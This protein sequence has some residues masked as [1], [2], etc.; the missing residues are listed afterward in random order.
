MYDLEIKIGVDN[1]NTA[2][3]LAQLAEQLKILGT[4]T[5]GVTRQLSANTS[6]SR[7]NAVAMTDEEKAAAQLQKAQE[8]LRAQLE[9]NANTYGKSRSEVMAYKAAQLGLANDVGIS[10]NIQKLHQAELD[11]ASN[12]INRAKGVVSELGKSNRLT[13]NETLNLSRQLSDV[14]VTAAMGMNPLMIMIQQGPQIA[15]V[16]Q[17]ASMRGVG[18]RAALLGIAEAAAPAIVVLGSLAAIVAP[19][20]AAFAL[21]ARE[22][23]KQSEEI[24]KSIGMTGKQLDW[25]KEKGVNTSITMGDYF[26]AYV[27]TVVDTL[28]NMFA[29]ALERLSKWWNT[30]LD[31]MYKTLSSWVRNAIIG[32]AALFGYINNMAKS[33]PAIFMDAM[34]QVLNVV[35][36]SFAGMINNLIL[37]WNSFKMAINAG[38][39]ELKAHNIPVPDINLKMS[40]QVSAP[41]FKSN[42]ALKYSNSLSLIAANSGAEAADR[43]MNS[44][45]KALGKNVETVHLERLTSTKGFKDEFDKDGKG[46]KGK[47][48]K[49]SEDYEADLEALKA[50]GELNEKLTEIENKIKA[51]E[52]LRPA[53]GDAARAALSELQS[54]YEQRKQVII[55]GNN[56]L[57]AAHLK[58]EQNEGRRKIISEQ[59]RQDNLKAEEDYQAKL[60][61]LKNKYNSEALRLDYE[62]AKQN[63][64]I[65]REE[66]EDKKISDLAE[67]DAQIEALKNKK[68]RNQ[69]FTADDLK[70]LREYY[71]QRIQI[72]TNAIKDMANLEKDALSLHK[73]YNEIQGNSEGAA[74]DDR[75]IAKLDN[76]T[77]KDINKE[78]TT[79]K[80]QLSK[81][82]RDA[83]NES[84][85]RY[86]N[87]A[88]QIANSWRNMLTGLINGTRSWRDVWVSVQQ[89]LLNAALQYGQRILINFIANQR[90]KALAAKAGSD[91]EAVIEKE[92]ANRK[93]QMSFKETIMQIKNDAVSVYSGVTKF[94]SGLVGPL[95][96][97]FGAAA[98]A[99]VVALSA[100]VQ[101]F[102]AEGGYDV[103]SNGSGVDGKGGR[104]G[105]VHPREMV[106][107]RSIADD[108]R[109]TFAGKIANSNTSNNNTAVNTDNSNINIS[110]HKGM[111]ADD[112]VKAIIRAKRQGKLSPAN[113]W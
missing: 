81:D 55:N 6:E 7:K 30:T 104:L 5:D 90:Q 94:M 89:G 15:D 60:T 76:K 80:K 44:F 87:A 20:F 68:S 56:A 93:G 4:N 92:G 96:P 109:A 14:A 34:S 78:T 36:G 47:K 106:L 103:P 66:I 112:I 97:A 86:R 31:S 77:N 61:E 107:P 9:M 48:G 35:G 70:Q 63:G 23:S 13:A 57:E 12:M 62:V 51:K 38:I 49:G 11:K 52:A 19:F 10:T 110:T 37:L 69:E 8:R 16:F 25:L 43:W 91:A 3:T 54:L 101:M 2:P 28:N 64:E 105:I 21:G 17:T 100:G 72:I 50:Q 1:S 73:K 40:N 41:E 84:V 74:E 58:G 26:K 79:N 108:F 18:L 59:T 46:K 71:N 53:T 102:S 113:A 24:N 45:N 98:A 42:G 27:K 29:P 111:N 85:E 39:A 82:E 75:A 88:N 95:A 67:V 65:K 83:L 22:V 33:M 32:W 99:S